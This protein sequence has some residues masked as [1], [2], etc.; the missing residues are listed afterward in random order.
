MSEAQCDWDVSVEELDRLRRAE[1]DFFLLD[2]RQPHEVEQ[3]TLGGVNIPLAEIAQ[4]L[5]EIPK[6]KKVLGHCKSG[7]RRAKAVTALRQLG[8]DDV[9]NVQGGTLAWSARIDPALP[10]Y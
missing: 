9:W 10:T 2:V 1:E 3:A 7:G 6:S 5:D 4:S 8:Y